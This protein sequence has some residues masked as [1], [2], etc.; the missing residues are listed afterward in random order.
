MGPEA[1]RVALLAPMPS[2]LR[3]LLRRLSLR[4]DPSGDRGA[5]RGLVGEVEVR[6]RPTG[7]G[8]ERAARATEALLDEGPADHVIVVGVAGGIGPSVAIGDLVVP[9][10]V[11]DLATGAEHRP[12]ALGDA[13]PRGTLVTSDGLLV[14]PAA[15]ARLAAEG[16]V[17]ID[18]ES[19][20]VAAVC[21]RRGC[22]FSVVR[23]ISD[24]ADDGSVDDAI[25]AL[26]RPD[27]SP[28][29]AA[30][31]RFVLTRPG[32]LP[33]LVRLGRD[34]GRATDAAA[35]AC[36]RALEAMAS[37]AAEQP[38]RAPHAGSGCRTSLS[39]IDQ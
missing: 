14:D 3:P 35:A 28:D 30:V 39:S 8:V 33:R 4:R 16:V 20:A 31:A 23:A 38:P 11:V 5:W 9:A 13:A 7:I 27:G 6:A 34:L 26:A 15:Y 37:R 24:R 32:R 17:A 18:M 29:L 25:F 36:V 22:P 21:A 1:R 19:A 2:E 12:E 10:R